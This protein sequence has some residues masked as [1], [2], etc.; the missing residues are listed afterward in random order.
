M[1]A[2][3]EAAIDF[4][5]GGDFKGFNH[6]GEFPILIVGGAVVEVLKE[7]PLVYVPIA[8]QPGLAQLGPSLDLL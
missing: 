2:P 8:V 6:M 1:I 5:V 3:V 7:L 4:P